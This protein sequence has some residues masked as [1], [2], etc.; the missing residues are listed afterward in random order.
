MR[1]SSG[2]LVFGETVTPD[3]TFDESMHICPVESPAES[4]LEE[5]RVMWNRLDQVGCFYDSV[6]Y[7]RM[8]R[9][10][11]LYLKDMVDIRRG[12]RAYYS[13]GGDGREMFGNTFSR[14]QRKSQEIFIL[15]CTKCVQE[16]RP[17]RSADI[18][19][20]LY[21]ARGKREWTTTTPWEATAVT[22]APNHHR[23]SKRQ[24]AIPF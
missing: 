5:L 3:S 11:N 1:L 22:T 24:R 2:P 7:Y 18:Q 4:T 19:S 8:N 6:G 13:L 10:R 20:M 14:L 9:Q 23:P 17:L 16:N 12:G 15:C 21:E